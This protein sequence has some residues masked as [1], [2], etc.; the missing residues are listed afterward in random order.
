MSPTSFEIILINGDVQ[1]RYGFETNKQKVSKEWLYSKQQ[2]KENEIF[3]RTNQ[4]FEDSG[5]IEMAKD[6][7]SKKMIREN[8][9]FLSV[10]A[11]FNDK[12]RKECS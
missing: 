3:Y 4:K 12:H 9:L 7:I 10:L 6:L 11:Q 2:L 1:F 8:A 5:R